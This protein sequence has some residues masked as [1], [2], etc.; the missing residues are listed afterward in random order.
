VRSRYRPSVGQV[1]VGKATGQL[2][3][4]VP[5]KTWE[6]PGAKEIVTALVTAI[7]DGGRGGG[8]DVYAQGQVGRGAQSVGAVKEWLEEQV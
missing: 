4:A 5:G 1:L 2:V 7:G 6:G 3:V 8:S